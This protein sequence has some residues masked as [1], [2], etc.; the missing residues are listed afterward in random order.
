MAKKK[1]KK[2]KVN[3]SRMN[4]NTRTI[5]IIILVIAIPFAVWGLYTVGTSLGVF[6]PPSEVE[7]KFRVNIINIRT[8]DSL[9]E[10]TF[11]L[12][13]FTDQTY[14]LQNQSQETIFEP[15]FALLCFVNYTG[16]YPSTITIEAS[17]VSL[18]P[19][20]NTVALYPLPTAID[21]QI[22]NLNGT[23]GDFTTADFTDL[24]GPFS[25]QLSLD[26]P[27]EY[28]GWAVQYPNCTMDDESYAYANESLHASG[29]WLAFNCSITNITI[30]GIEFPVYLNVPVNGV[31]YSVIPL[32]SVFNSDIQEITMDID[33]T[34]SDVDILLYD[35]LIDAPINLVDI[36]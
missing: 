3:P 18:T 34:G 14:Y 12:I 5:L 22:I 19:K 32:F 1:L 2:G 17:G 6:T 33:S 11:D 31:N 10:A 24:A 9:P 25:M 23:Y 7:G 35:G 15:G 21:Y 28:F 16:Y 30:K 8:G 13:N 26:I 29:L 36:I 4:S 27:D 20:N